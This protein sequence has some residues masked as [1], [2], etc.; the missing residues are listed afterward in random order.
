MSKCYISVD[1]EGAVSEMLP[2]YSSMLSL[3]ACVVGKPKIQFYEELIP[4]NKNWDAQAE[5]IHGLT[6]QHLGAY[7]KDPRTVME[8]FRV[9]T[10]RAASGAQPVF[11]AMP[12]RYDWG[13]VGWYFQTAEQEDKDITNPYGETLDGTELFHIVMRIPEDARVTRSDIYKLFPP[14]VPHTHNA[15]DDAV[16]QEEVF[17]QMLRYGKLL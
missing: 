8:M 1:V 3:G 17:R 16:E 4:L 10:L 9:W 5:A 14:S 15:L 7:G 2:P 6:R 11:C 12:L 13:Y